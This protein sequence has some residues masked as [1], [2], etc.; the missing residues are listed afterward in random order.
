[1]DDVARLRVAGHFLRS[2]VE[3]EP[4]TLDR[5]GGNP[6]RNTEERRGS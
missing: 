3:R 1:M 4:I 6:A 5:S 2:G